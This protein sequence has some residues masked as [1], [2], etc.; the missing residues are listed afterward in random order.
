MAP[1]EARRRARN[2]V[3][4]IPLLAEQ[5]RDQRRVT[6][7]YD[8]RHDVSFG[9]RMLGKQP[10][11]TCVAVASLALGIGAN[12]AILGAMDAVVRGSLSIPQS[13][14]I[15][16]VRTFPQANRRQETH[17]SLDDY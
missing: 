1:D 10:A 14:R 2:T 8:L 9:V 16:V 4:N 6:W 5:C 11:F 15:V 17:A 3:G 12:T 7:L 13:A